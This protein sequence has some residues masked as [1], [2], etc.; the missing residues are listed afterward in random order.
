MAGA[1][2]IRDGRVAADSHRNVKIIQGFAPLRATG[3]MWLG[4]ANGI[5]QAVPVAPCLRQHG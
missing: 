3:W 1:G 4:I 5:E 2:E